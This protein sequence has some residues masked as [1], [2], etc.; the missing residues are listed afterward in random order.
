DDVMD[1]SAVRRG[2]PSVM[3]K[4]GV[5]AAILSGDAMLTFATQFVADCP[6][7]VMPMVL[8]CFNTSA[9]MV[10]E[11]QQLDIDF[12]SREHVD[13]QEYIDMIRLK[14]AALLACAAKIGALVARASQ[15]HTESIYHFAE[16]LGIA[17]QVQDD[18]LDVYGDAE[19]FGKPIG[20][21]IVNYKKT[22][23]L[24]T[25]LSSPIA[26]DIKRAMMIADNDMKIRTVRELYD[27]INM[28]DLCQ[29]T[30]AYYTETA[31]NAIPS[32]ISTEG[33]TALRNLAEKLIGRQQ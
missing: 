17:F 31:L 25:A 13:L 5:N 30:V 16:N 22:F 15:L 19:I 27:S 3:A 8:D 11:G 33:A 26:A 2:R 4:Y 10:Y 24:L 7:D 9:M 23:L 21:D 32:G 28:R 12:E 20:G 1:N 29:R 18:F 6:R 14:T